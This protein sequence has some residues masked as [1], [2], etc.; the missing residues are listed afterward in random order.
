MLISLFYNPCVTMI[1]NFSSLNL[2][3]LKSFLLDIYRLN[4]T[5][6]RVAGDP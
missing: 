1:F 5:V 6:L 2:Y 4:I 3:L